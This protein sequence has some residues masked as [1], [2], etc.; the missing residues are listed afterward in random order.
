MKLF[1]MAVQIL[2][3]REEIGNLKTEIYSKKL[4]V[5][6][7]KYLYK[8]V[9]E[10]FKFSKNYLQDL[11]KNIPRLLLSREEK[12]VYLWEFLLGSKKILSKEIKKNKTRIQA[13]FVRIV[14]KSGLKNEECFK[15]LRVN[16]LKTTKESVLMHFRKKGILNF[17]KEDEIFSFLLKVNSKMDL[18]RDEFYLQGKVVFQDKACCFSAHVLLE[19]RSGFEN[20]QVI[21]ATAAP[22]NKTSHLAMIMGNKGRIFAFERDFKRFKV[23]EKMLEKAGV[24]N[25]V[26]KNM[27]FLQVNPQEYKDVQYILLDPSCSG[28]GIVSRLEFQDSKKDSL[29]RLE[30]LSNFQKEIILHAFKFPSVQKV[31]Y[32]TCSI[33]REEN[34]DVVKYILE[35]QA[36]FVLEENVFPEWTRRGFDTDDF[37]QGILFNF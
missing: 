24:E 30:S 34:E 9:V 11:E 3:K 29:E 28:S 21:D 23:L 36:D 32:S 19:G 33:H 13:E 4:S 20:V 31:V 22:G 14:L 18:S 37:D 35:N 1:K 10:S 16:D 6:D 17:I 8:I 2:C 7:Q 12:I 27:D 25:T 15:F 5:K 26:A